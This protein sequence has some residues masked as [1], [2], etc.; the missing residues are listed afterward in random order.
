VRLLAEAPELNLFRPFPDLETSE[1]AVLHLE[2]RRVLGLQVKTVGIDAV[3][4]DAEVTILASS[5][6]PSPT[7][8]FAVLAWL[9]QESRFHEECL[10]IPSEAIPTIAEPSEADGHI[11]FAWHPGSRAESRVNQYRHALSD[12]RALSTALISG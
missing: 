7:T 12:L 5:F 9:R 10:L 8:C 6:R 11:K 2:S 3:H 4:V 1:L